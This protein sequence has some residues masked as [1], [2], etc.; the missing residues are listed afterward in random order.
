LLLIIK[1]VSFFKKYYYSEYLLLLLKSYI[2]L[3]SKIS[4]LSSRDMSYKS[5]GEDMYK[6][7]GPLCSW[8]RLWKKNK[9][10]SSFFYYY[11][12]FLL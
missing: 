2:S 10:G 7:F 6:T 9:R 8:D 12:Y 3:N 1:I 11:Y 5:E 4:K